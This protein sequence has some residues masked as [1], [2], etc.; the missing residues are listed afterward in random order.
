MHIDEVI[1]ENRL[2]KDMGD[3][4]QLALSIKENG[5][6]QPLVLTRMSENDL[7]HYRLI[8]G[9]RRLE[10]LRSLGVTELIHAEH[11]LLREEL[12]DDVYRRTAIELE[13]NIRRKQMSWSEEV[14]GKQRLLETYQKIYGAPALGQPSK[15]VQQ[16]LK[17]AGFGVRKLSEL[18]NESAGQTSEDLQM[19]ALVTQIPSLKNEPSRE[20]ATRK[21]R[22]ALMI[23]AGKAG[24][25][26]AKPLLYKIVV[27]CDSE[28]HQIALL[29]QFRSAGLK[30]QAVVA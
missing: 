13:E 9:H 10:A 1:I 3:I 27:E 24:V 12:I 15:T 17:P 25:H 18:L 16:G 20:A 29:T 6:I 7:V 5:L 11:Y 23:Q 22:L 30:C 19:A 28:E 21:L 26:M 4:P 14:L 2:R 8:A